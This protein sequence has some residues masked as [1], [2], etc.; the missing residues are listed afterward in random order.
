M[1]ASGTT[2]RSTIFLDKPIDNTVEKI[3]ISSGVTCI[4]NGNYLLRTSTGE[5]TTGFTIEESEHS[6]FALPFLIRVSSKHSK[7]INNDAVGI[8]LKDVKITFQ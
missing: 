4:Q 2:Y 8:F 7:A 3:V 6:L 1:T 5:V